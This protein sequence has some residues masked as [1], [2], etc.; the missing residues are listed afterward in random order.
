MNIAEAG[1]TPQQSTA[2]TES[3]KSQELGQ[4]AFL[5]LLTVQLKNQDPLEPIKNEDFL[6][7]LAQFSSLEKLEQI[8]QALSND[9]EAR[10]TAGIQ[11]AVE[12]NTAVSLIGKEVDIPTDTIT[13]AGNGSL[14]IGYNLSGPANSLAVQIFNGE[15]NLVRTLTQ[16]SPDAGNGS[17]QW[18]GKNPNGQQLPEGAYHIV[19]EAVNGQGNAVRVSAALTGKVTGVR[20]Q[21]GQPILLLDGGEAPLSGVSRISQ[22]E[23]S[24]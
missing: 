20:Y 8:H 2:L 23:S 18:D 24:P 1:F 4:D 5:K 6:A 14:D 9:D 19:P 22:T 3:L 13:Y 15:G 21:D 17:V 12:S 16:T 7:Q 10:A 11:Q